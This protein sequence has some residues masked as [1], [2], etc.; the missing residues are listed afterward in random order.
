M[1]R[2]LV[3]HARRKQALKRAG[4]VEQVA[5]DVALIAAVSPDV[6]LIAL[7]EALDL[8]AAHDGRKA[9]LVKLRYFGGLTLREAADV[10]GISESTADADWAYAKSWLR[11]RMDA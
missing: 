8:L 7:N 4:H 5:V 9:E 6:D 3:D 1:R 11:M 10:L 2:I